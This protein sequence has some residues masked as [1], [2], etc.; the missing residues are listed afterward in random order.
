[1]IPHPAHTR[2][3]QA[4]DVFYAQPSIVQGASGTFGHDL[5]LGFMWSPAERMLVDGRP[6]R[7]FD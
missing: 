5:V 1:M 4:V 7:L 2:G 3:K 6:M